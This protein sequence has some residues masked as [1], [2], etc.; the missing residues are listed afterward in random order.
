MSEDSCDYCNWVQDATGISYIET[1]NDAKHLTMHET[2]ST[3]K[4]DLA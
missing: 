1:W 3:T 4:N 2:A